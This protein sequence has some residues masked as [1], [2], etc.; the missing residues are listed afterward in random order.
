M[1]VGVEPA[2]RNGAPSTEQHELAKFR[3]DQAGA[4][5]TLHA[6]QHIAG[7]QRPGRPPAHPLATPH[8]PLLTRQKKSK[9]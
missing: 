6:Q 1:G 8:T 9:R 4:H 7:H 3:A 2:V 5:P